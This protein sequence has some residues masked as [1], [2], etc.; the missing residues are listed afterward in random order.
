MGYYFIEGGG[1]SLHINLFGERNEV[2][3]GN[4]LLIS[5]GGCFLGGETENGRCLAFLAFS[6]P[7]KKSVGLEW[8]Q[9]GRALQG[10]WDSRLQMTCRMGLG[11]L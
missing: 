5:W 4:D 11:R 8:I 2:S 1:K 9:Q 6:G 7:A 10:E 3:V